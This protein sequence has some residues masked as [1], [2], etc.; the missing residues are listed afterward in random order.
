MSLQAQRTA[1]DLTGCVKCN[2]NLSEVQHM[3]TGDV[4]RCST[5]QSANMHDVKLA[6]VE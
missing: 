2:Y 3:M 1:A 6:S 4:T 5:G